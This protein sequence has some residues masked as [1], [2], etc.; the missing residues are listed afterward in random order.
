MKRLILIIALC[1]LALAGCTTTTTSTIQEP[2]IGADGQVLK[3]TSGNVLIRT[4]TI[5]KTDYDRAMDGQVAFES[6]KQHLVDMEA[7]N[8]VT[9]EFK[10]DAD[11]K[12]ISKTVVTGHEPIVISGAKRFTVGLP[13]NF[14]PYQSQIVQGLR[15]GAAYMPLLAPFAYG[16]AG[17]LFD[18]S[19]YGG[20][21]GGYGSGGGTYVDG[22]LT[23]T[24]GQAPIAF[25]SPYQNAPVAY[26]GSG[27][28][29]AEGVPIPGGAA[30]VY[31]YPTYTMPDSSQTTFG[32]NW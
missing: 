1:S 29:S 6:K 16:L 31:N 17:S 22:N 2:M 27:G 7:A 21:A 24:G 32:M 23:I 18:Y 20:G 14:K 26:G 4:R 12:V 30:N 28:V 3:D 9:T 11:G 15:A 5:E 10:Y 25:N 8:T 19:Y 13:G